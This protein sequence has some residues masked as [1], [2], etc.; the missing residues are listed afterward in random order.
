MNLAEDQSTSKQTQKKI[1]PPPSYQSLSLKLLLVKWDN[2]PSGIYQ[3]THTHLALCVYSTTQQVSQSV[4]D[5][6]L[7]TAH[8]ASGRL[9]VPENSEGNKLR[10]TALM[11][12]P[13]WTL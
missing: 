13:L 4:H 12:L 11:E 1:P 5:R 10:A 9:Q 3:H 8:D 7:S 2:G 6:Y